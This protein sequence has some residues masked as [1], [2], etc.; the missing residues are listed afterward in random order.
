MGTTFEHLETE[1]LKLAP[2]ER[3]KLVELLTAS[4]ASELGPGWTEEIT[5]RVACMEAGQS[6]F[7]PAHETLAEMRLYMGQRRAAT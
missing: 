1:A 6:T 3:R 7:A 4:L 2:P 5:R